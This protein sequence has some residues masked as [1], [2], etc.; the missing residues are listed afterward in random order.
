M[1]RY[2]YAGTAEER[3]WPRVEK[4]ETCWNWT[5]GKNGKGYGYSGSRAGPFRRT[6]CPTIGRMD[7]CQTGSNGTTFV[8]IG[9]VFVLGLDTSNGGRCSITVE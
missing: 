6:R 3:F 7:R 4:T 2:G 9:C 1:F 5:A 8:R